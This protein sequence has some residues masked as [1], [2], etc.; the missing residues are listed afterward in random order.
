[1]RTSKIRVLVPYMLSYYGGVR[2]LLGDGLPY[3]QRISDIEVDYAELCLNEGDMADMEADGVPVNRNLGLHGGGKLSSRHGFLRKMDLLRVTPSLARL[4]MRIRGSLK[5][6]DIVYV[7]GYRELLLTCAAIHLSCLGKWPDIVWHCHGV[8]DEPTPILAALANRCRRVV[9]ISQDVAR[10][11]GEIGVN[12]SRVQVI[13]NAIDSEKV[14]CLSREA[15]GDLPEKGPNCT[16][17]LVPSASIRKIKGL[18][19]AINAIVDLPES[20]CLWITG[21]PED[22]IA[23]GYKKE[24]DESIER[25][26]LKNRVHFI[27]WRTD[28]FWV[29]R[30]CDVVLV[31]SLWKE[32]FGLVAAEAMVL[33]KPVIVSDRGG[34]PEVV[35]SR[36]YGWIFDPDNPKAMASCVQS[37][38]MDP[39]EAKRRAAKGKIRIENLFGFERWADEVAREFYS[40]YSEPSGRLT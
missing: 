22:P 6:Y 31:P 2:R 32:P 15:G 7:H 34:L 11:L 5:K 39:A 14:R 30:S 24:L 16:A 40:C 18:H 9:A 23:K 13:Y 10:R 25:Q 8:G 17:I 21:D 1:M 36:E 33:E 35:G 20:C 29:I 12:P 4:V 27:G 38:L 28:I 37:I 3:L 26:G 19:V